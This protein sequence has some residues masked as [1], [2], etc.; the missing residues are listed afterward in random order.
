MD[1]AARIVCGSDLS[2]C[3]IRFLH[4]ESK[5]WRD[6][7]EGLEFGWAGLLGL[8]EFVKV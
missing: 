7:R 1:G 6:Y 5:G 2:F 3:F 8:W 4:T